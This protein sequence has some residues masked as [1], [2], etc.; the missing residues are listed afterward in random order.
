M[1][2]HRPDSTHTKGVAAPGT[3]V[4]PTRSPRPSRPGSIPMSSPDLSDAD[5]RAVLD[6]M[7]TPHLSMGPRVDAFEDAVRSY[8]GSMEAVAVNSGT[9]GLHLAV[10]GM[11][12]EEGD[13]VV[14]TPFSFIASA[15]CILYE[16]AIPIFVDVDPRT[17]NIDPR[18]VEQ[19]V[20]DISGGGEDAE[21][22]MP[23]VM[24]GGRH[25]RRLKAIIPV[26]VF[27][28]PADMDAI[29][30]V[31]SRYGLAV[32]E[33]ACEA[34]GSQYKGRPAGTM[35]DVG[36]FGFYPNKQ[37]TTGEGGMI[38]TDNLEMSE[39]GR[40]LRNQ[41]RDSPRL[42]YNYRMDELSAA[43]GAAQLERVDQIVSRRRQV[44][45]W[46]DERLQDI[47]LIERP[48]VSET[49]TRQSWFAYVVQVR[50]PADRTRVIHQLAA[51]EIP[52]RPYFPAIH[53]Q[54][55]YR[56]QFG[57]REGDFPVTERLGQTSLGLPFSGV[58][59]EGEVDEVCDRL[60]LSL[61]TVGRGER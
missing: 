41:G 53:L 47:E 13:L 10:I 43:L 27:G 35:G 57:Y 37:I 58:M 32:I 33:D 34:L 14:T 28:Q 48:C 54:P 21:R 31:A 29:L 4:V 15:N 52:S 49:T 22:W 2:L 25:P 30:Q 59:S 36:V 46:Y 11:D 6:V 44:A 19:A 39:L 23:P 8:L 1:T 40:S 26:H 56:D 16:R 9:S 17:G 20:A 18:L 55:F 51:Y 61:G 5:V 38:V 7:R 12:V 3:M 60:R 50:P 45:S 42:G 24:R